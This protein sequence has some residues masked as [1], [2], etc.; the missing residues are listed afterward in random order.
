MLLVLV[1]GCKVDRKVDRTAD[2]WADHRA[3]HK[4]EGDH[5]HGSDSYHIGSA[6]RRSMT[7]VETLPYPAAEVGDTL[8]LWGNKQQ[9]WMKYC[10]TP[11]IDCLQVKV[12][13]KWFRHDG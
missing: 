10:Q 8:D 3:D 13:K 9:T 4:V 7:E 2:R 5:R 1:A 11:D 12:I 6:D